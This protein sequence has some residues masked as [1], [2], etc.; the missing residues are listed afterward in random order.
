MTAQSV[1]TDRRALGG[2]LLVI[3]ATLAFATADVLTKHLASRYGVPLVVFLRYAV[4]LALLSAIFL[5]RDGLGLMRT[6]RT[7]LVLV[8]AASLAVASLAMGLAL[9][10]MPV[11]ETVAITYLAPFAVMLLAGP[12]LGEK[13]R[14][15]GW[16][17][18]AAGFV[19]VLLIVRPGS[20]LDLTGV[21]FAM[22]C[23]AASTAYHLLSRV[24]ARTETT[25]ALLFHTAL[26]GTVVFG[27]LLP[28]SW[29]GLWPNLL[30]TALLLALGTIATIG[31]FLFTS[32]FRKAPASLLAP[33]NYVHLV[34]AGGLG[35]LI[36]DHLPAPLSLLGMALVAGAGVSV[37]LRTWRQ[38]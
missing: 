15:A 21:V 12:I 14:L 2:V 33:V 23:A 31:H 19:G 5:P 30:D 3:A 37:A 4:N 24:L 9:Q 26:L 27:L 22:I 36:F 28:F 7:G 32:A 25:V 16:L 20:G 10:R 35:W 1:Q 18:A 13:V 34:W 38:R 11:G 6:H 17:G 8:R 29:P